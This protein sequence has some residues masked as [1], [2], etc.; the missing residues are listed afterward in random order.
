KVMARQLEELRYCQSSPESQAIHTPVIVSGENDHGDEP[1]AN[2]QKAEDAVSPSIT[3]SGAPEEPSQV[4]RFGPWKPID[5]SDSRSL[6]P[7]QRKHLDDL[8][9]RYTRRTAKSKELTAAHRSHL[10]DPRAVAGFRA[11]WK[12]MV[13]PIVSVRSSGSK[14]WDVDGNAYVDMMM[15]FGP[16]LFGHSPDFVIRALEN[17]L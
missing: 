16:A 2:R 15:G 9:K 13:Y 4:S 3:R 10:A 8:I 1:P 17:Q 7:Q 11:E 5:K 6:D 12:E 14:L